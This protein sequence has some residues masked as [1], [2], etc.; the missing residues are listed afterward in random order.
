MQPISTSILR[1]PGIII[2]LKFVEW[3]MHIDGHQAA[4]L[5]SPARVF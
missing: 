4:Q 2:A 5:N 3:V 1:A